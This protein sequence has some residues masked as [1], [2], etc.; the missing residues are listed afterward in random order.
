MSETASARIA[1]RLDRLP[2]SRTIWKIVL[3]ISLGGVFE[4]YDLFFTAYVAP[5]MMKSGLF[6]PQSLG[7][8]ASLDSIKIAGFG[9]FVFSTFAGLW[10]G[11]VL[12]G[13]MADRFGRRPVFTWSLVWYVACTAIMAF[14]HSGEMLNVWRFIAGVGFAVQ[15]V[16]IDTYISELIPSAERGRAFS[17]NQFI[18]FAVVPVV[19]LLA[20]LLVPLSPLGID[21]WRWVVLIGSMGAVLVWLLVQG[22][23]E[24]PRWL[25]LQGRTDEAESIMAAIEQRVARETGTPLPAPALAHAE[26]TGRGHFAEIFSR[27]YRKRTLMLSVF[28]MAQVIGFYGFAAWVPTLLIARGVTVTHSLEYSFVIAIAN[29]LGPLLGVLFADRIERKLQIMLG[30]VVMGLSMLAFAMASNP[31]LLVLLGVMF[32]LAANVMSYAY[33]NYQAELYPT[34]IRSRAVGF[35]YSWS[36]LA[37]AFAGLAVG[38]LLHAGGALA[39]AMFIAIAMVVGIAMIGIFGPQTKGVA[40]EEISR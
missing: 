37:A 9:T 24:S 26:E 4:F 21:G 28:N 38:Y 2:P 5:G 15:L 35:V 16:T 17:V 3:W 31:V 25:A 12:F 33:H 29:P 7:F 27:Q 39:V 30:L 13:H 11:V 22:I 34:R 19:A 8:F 20:W 14:Q 32:T 36:R 40:L 6:T 18:T 10:V 23:P 1:A